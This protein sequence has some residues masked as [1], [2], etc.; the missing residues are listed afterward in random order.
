[1]ECTEKRCFGKRKTKG[2]TMT[3]WQISKKNNNETWIMIRIGKKFGK[4]EV[5]VPAI[6]SLTIVLSPC[7]RGRHFI[8]SYGSGS[9]RRDY[10]SHRDPSEEEHPSSGPSYCSEQA[11]Q[12]SALPSWQ[13]QFADTGHCSGQAGLHAS[14]LPGLFIRAPSGRRRLAGWGGRSGGQ[15]RGRGVVTK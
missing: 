15:Y 1:M 13:H 2:E 7:F 10:Y 3:P 14:P 5:S 12:H 11:S 4:P 8:F 6:L 9:D